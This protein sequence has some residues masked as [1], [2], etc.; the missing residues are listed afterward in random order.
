LVAD[1]V[2]IANRR[3]DHAAASKGERPLI[4]VPRR[5]Q[6]RPTNQPRLARDHLVSVPRLMQAIIKPP[7]V[8]FGASSL[9]QA[10]SVAEDS[11]QGVSAPAYRT[12][13]RPK[14]Y[15]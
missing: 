11:G 10:A 4:P 9:G 8:P 6:A 3:F 14:P 2:S 5:D 7:G 15:M 13:S 12:A 1:R